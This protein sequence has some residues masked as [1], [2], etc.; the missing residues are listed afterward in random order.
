MGFTRE[1]EDEA[2]KLGFLFYTRAG[3]DPD[4]FGDFFATMIKMGGDQGPEI[5]S[6]HPS[7]SSRVA[8]A[9]ERASKLPPN[10]EQWH[11]PPVADDRAFARIKARATEVG[12]DMPDDTSLEQS[13]ELLAAMPRSCLTPAIQPDQQAAEQRVLSQA[14]A[15]QEGT[16]P[17]RPTRAQR[18]R[19]RQ[20]Q[21]E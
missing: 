18:E 21:Q 3:W 7:L 8:A 12:K 11:R 2:D 17:K 19:D 4:K 13:Q 1:D 10:A 16:A 6:D 15:E 20:R 9:K 14:K 5:L